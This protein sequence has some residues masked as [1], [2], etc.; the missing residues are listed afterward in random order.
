M[1]INT[2][3][4]IGE[5]VM[6]H[7]GPNKI[8]TWGDVCR[9]SATISKAGKINIEYWVIFGDSCGLWIKEE[10]LSN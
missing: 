7:Y 3:Y 4:E 1:I 10:N 2:K 9:I 8:K 6:F 5:P